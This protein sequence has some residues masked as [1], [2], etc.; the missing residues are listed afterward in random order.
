[1]Q[2]FR[3]YMHTLYECDDPMKS[4]EK[5]GSRLNHRKDSLPAQDVCDVTPCEDRALTVTGVGYPFAVV[6]RLRVLQIVCGISALVMGAVAFIEERGRLHLGLG[7]PAGVLTVAAA[8]MSIHTSRG[9]SGYTSPSCVPP[10]S[11]FRFLG[12]SVRVA[13][14]L[15]LL[16]T[17]SVALHLV[18]FAFCLGSL[19]V[20]S[21]TTVIASVLMLISVLS[22][23][24]IALVLRIDCRYDP[25]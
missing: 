24:A 18:V 9:F 22:L 7:M 12:P 4:I 1:M 13:V 6:L 25:D 16:W 17:S 11:L 23:T 20:S 15:T 2:A 3:S 21:Q 14:P 19:F 5:E 10:L 8:A